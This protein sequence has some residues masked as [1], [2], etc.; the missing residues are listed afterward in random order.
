MIDGG[1]FHPIVRFFDWRDFGNDQEK[2][3]RRETSRRIAAA[4][5][6]NWFSAVPR[7][8]MAGL[9]PYPAE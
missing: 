9:K 5:L 1:H 4:Q 8:Y 6:A 7:R 3:S 2:E